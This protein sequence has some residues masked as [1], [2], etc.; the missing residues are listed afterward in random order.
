[1]FISASGLNKQFNYIQGILL[2]KKYHPSEKL[3]NGEL[4]KLSITFGNKHKMDQITKWT[5]G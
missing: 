3:G 4:Y 5:N 1:M 2:N